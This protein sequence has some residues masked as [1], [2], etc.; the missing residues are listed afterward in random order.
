MAENVLDDFE[1]ASTSRTRVTKEW[2]ETLPLSF[3]SFLLTEP[4]TVLPFVMPLLWLPR[5]DGLALIGLPLTL[6]ELPRWVR[7]A[8][9]L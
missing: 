8:N 7:P 2:A 3:L 4:F 6:L 9:G 5:K 1:R